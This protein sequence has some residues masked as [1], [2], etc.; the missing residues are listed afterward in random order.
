[1]A[2][3][4]GIYDLLILVD[5]TYSMSDYLT[6]LQTSIPKIVSISALTDCFSRI[7]LLAYRDYGDEDLIQWIGW[8]RPR[9]DDPV[10]NELSHEDL[11]LASRNIHPN[12]GGDYPEATKTGLAKAYQEMREDATTIIL[13]YTDAPPHT[14]ANGAGFTSDNHTLEQKALT[15]TT[16]YG[17]FGPDF[18]DWVHGGRTLALKEGGKKRAQVFSIL[19][20]SMNRADG[21]YYTFLSTITGGACFYLKKSTPKDIAQVTVD[22]LLAWMGVEKSGTVVTDIEAQLARFKHPGGIEHI[23]K[24]AGKKAKPN[25][26]KAASSNVEE[27][28]VNSAVLKKYMPKREVEVQDFAARY[29]SDGI[30]KKLVVEHLQKII[31]DDVSAISLNPVFG[32]LWRAVC[33]DRENP[34]RDTLITSFGL[35]VDRVTN[36]DERERM[37]AWL[38]ESYDYTAEVQE[39]IDSV[40]RSQQFPCVY[41]DPT[42][43]FIKSGHSEGAHEDEDDRPMTEFGR[44]ELLEIGRS[45]DYRILRRLGRVLTRLTFVDSIEQLPAHIANAEEGTITRIPM[46]LA[47]KELGRKFWG[48]LLHIVVPG[49]MLSARPAAL[50][51][52]L[53]ISLG[54]RPLLKSAHSEMRIWRSR[55]NDLEVPENWNV[56]CLS[57][58]LDADQAYVEQIKAEQMVTELGSKVEHIIPPADRELFERL[59]SYKMLELNL[60]TTLV[61]KV[62]WK[63]EKITMP[64]GPLVACRLCHYPRSVTMMGA[65]GTCGNCLAIDYS[66]AEERQQRINGRVSKDANETSDSTWVECCT[67]TCRAQYIV[68]HP[69]ALKIRSKCYYCREQFSLPENKRSI[70]PAPTVECIQCLSRVIYPFEYRPK[71]MLKSEYKCMGCTVGRKTI[72]DIETTATKLSKENSTAW[73]LSNKNDKLKEPLSGRSLFQQITQ[74][75]TQDFC[76]QVLL[77]PDS[78]TTTLTLKSKPLHNVPELITHLKDCISRLHTEKGTCSLCFSNLRKSDINPACGRHSCHQEICRPCLSAWYGLNSSGKIINISALSCPFCRRAP[79]AKTLH[80][81]GMGIHAI[82]NLSEA[83]EKRGQWIYA[84]CKD[85]ASAQ[86]YLERV[87]ARGAPPETTDFMCESCQQAAAEAAR[88]Q[89]AW[90]VAETARMEREG[91]HIH[92]E[93]RR[94]LQREAE[95][96]ALKLTLVTKDCPW[97][98]V[99][100]EKS[101]GCGHMACICGKHWCWF[102]G[103]GKGGDEIYEHMSWVHGGWYENEEENHW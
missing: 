74:S 20:P 64:I 32:S 88:R 27:L 60:K 58:L 37:K 66:T 14:T 48:I 30:Y 54:I 101:L 70:D 36:L 97:C 6:S 51:A 25:K 56:S 61:A 95:E 31:D 17:G 76:T 40:P 23:R 92:S 98:G 26:T 85:C 50:L 96:R 16:S 57:L 7:G 55:W 49:T 10:Q 84:W 68:Y 9:K 71:D 38:A 12:G 8:Q 53:S 52:A 83:V 24:E 100:T 21:D 94:A 103:E 2:A 79:T 13:L 4:T 81:Y 43:D 47:T 5:A 75:G 19:E 18:A 63:P 90:I 29:K 93:M 33:N 44:D 41:F 45:C 11:A 69:D 34:A 59:V 3:P 86:P 62:A 91:R 73:L 28:S 82:G 22:L 15:E 89:A 99:R 80:S 72:I 77:F 65:N 102:C 67:K 46:A 1:M 78:E 35:H 87:C 42:V 39:A